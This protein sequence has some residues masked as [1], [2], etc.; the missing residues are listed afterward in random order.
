MRLL[1]ILVVLLILFGGIGYGGYGGYYGGTPWSGP[2]YGGGL[3][4][5]FIIVLV[6]LALTGGL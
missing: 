2:F 6:V 5:L 1:L 3:V 4:T